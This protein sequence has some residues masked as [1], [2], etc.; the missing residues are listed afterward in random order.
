MRVPKVVLNRLTTKAKDQTYVFERLYRNLYNKAF[1]YDAYVKLYKND[2]EFSRNKS[3]QETN[4]VVLTRIDQ[5]IMRLKDRTYQPTSLR[6][7]NHVIDDK[8]LLP[9]SLLNLEDHLVEEI[10][11]RLLSHLFPPQLLD[12]TH[13]CEK[14]THYHTVLKNI[15]HTFADTVWFISASLDDCLCDIAPHILVD[16][17]RKRIRDEKFMHLIWKFIH[18]GYL[19][20]KVNGLDD[21]IDNQRECLSGLLLDIYLTELDQY[22]EHYH[23]NKNEIVNLDNGIDNPSGVNQNI[24][25]IHYA[26]YAGVFLLGINGDKKE[27]EQIKQDV[28]LFLKEKLQLKRKAEK[29]LFINSK[30]KVR[31]LG[32]DIRIVAN[33]MNAG[34]MLETDG[35]INMVRLFAP[36]DVCIQKLIKL[37]ALRMG[38][39]NH[40]KVMHRTYLVHKRDDEVIRS[41][42]GDINHFFNYYH[43]ASNLDVLKFFGET[44]KYSLVK[45]LANK[46]KLT[47]SQTIHKYHIRGKFNVHFD[48]VSRCKVASYLIKV[49]EES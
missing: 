1:Y 31:F 39:N 3:N 29:F 47:V 27:A 30:K 14:D 25:R 43:L 17:L 12:H 48:V 36:R 28:H 2:L 44:M 8:K 40:W 37:K 38:A 41:Y 46:Y 11:R 45:T 15:Q 24:R 20:G 4:D 33:Q 32:Y 6:P 9:S 5:L 10:V 18:A 34:N 23:M 16:I 49:N 19:K 21:S 35:Q 7:S 13:S 42:R 26:R 22:V